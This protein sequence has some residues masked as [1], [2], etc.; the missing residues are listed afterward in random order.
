MLPLLVTVEMSDSAAAAPLSAGT[1]MVCCAAASNAV[2]NVMTWGLLL[3]VV[4][5]S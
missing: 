1:F 3:S 4:P 2:A 5:L